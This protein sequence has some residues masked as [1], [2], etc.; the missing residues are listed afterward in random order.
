MKKK[1]LSL[2]L[3]AAM[4]LT[5]TVPVSAASVSSFKDVSTGSWYYDSVKYVAEKDYMNGT[6]ATTF[7]PSDNMTRAMFATVI[8]RVAGVT[9]D[10]SATTEFTDV[11][12]GMWY[13]G[14]VKWGVE[15]D[16]LEGYGNGRFGTDDAITRQ[17]IAVLTERFLTWYCEQNNKDI[18]EDALVESFTDVNSIAAYAKDSVEFCRKAGL[19]TGYEDGSFGPLGLTTRAEI[20]AIIERIEFVMD[21]AAPAVV[22]T[23]TDGKTATLAVKAGDVITVDPNGGSVTYDGKAYKDSFTITVTEDGVALPDATRSSYKFGGWKVTTDANGAYTF[24]AQWTRTGG[25]GGNPPSSDPDPASVLDYQ[26]SVNVKNDNRSLNLIAY[27]GNG[28]NKRYHVSFD[29][30]EKIIS[31]RSEDISLVNIAKDLCHSEDLE[32][33]IENLKEIKYNDETLIGEDGTIKDITVKTVEISQIVQKINGLDE[34]I[35]NAVNTV[36]VDSPIETDDVTNLLN[37]LDTSDNPTLTPTEKAIVDA[38]QDKLGEKTDQEIYNKVAE[39]VGTDVLGNLWENPV[40]AVNDLI[41]E[42]LK[43]LENISVTPENVQNTLSVQTNESA[44]NVKGGVPITINPAEVYAQQY[45]KEK[46]TNCARIINKIANLIGSEEYE[47]EIDALEESAK[48][49]AFKNLFAACAPEKIFDISN[50]EDETIYKLK[51]PDEYEAIL[52]DLIDKAEAVRQELII[53]RKV[54]EASMVEVLTKINNRAEYWLGESLDPDQIDKMASLI[55]NPDPQLTDVVK[56]VGEHEEVLEIEL[57][58][59]KLTKIFKRVFE[60]IGADAADYEDLVDALKEKLEGSY[61]AEITITVTTGCDE[62][63]AHD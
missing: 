29:D 39:I 50:L 15:N 60:G 41:D 6:S 28:D 20:A 22:Y 52:V 32:T 45:S 27:D 3:S 59:D 21:S 16:L 31:G 25:N 47:D 55:C 9:V 30:E 62:V 51:T 24:T 46:A 38:L 10:N 19:L 63:S 18:Q 5:L 35:V 2:A 42:Y 11:A 48:T 26:V 17:D 61:S 43:K 40:A 57:T 12:S 49:G 44:V 14:A 33:V 4:A 54:T 56:T 23:G 34:E 1:V 7:D 8:S 13:T 36:L 53:D 58:Q 37:K